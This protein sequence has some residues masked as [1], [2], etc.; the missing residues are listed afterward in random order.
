MIKV[1]NSFNFGD[2]TVC[3]KSLIAITSNKITSNIIA[4]I[5]K[6]KVLS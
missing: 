3:R 5:S 4:P 2:S 6:E 1:K